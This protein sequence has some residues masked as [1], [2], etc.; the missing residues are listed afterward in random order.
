MQLK[1]QTLKKKKIHPR[2]SGWTHSNQI[3]KAENF[4]W[5][6]LE[7]RGKKGNERDHSIE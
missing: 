4:L 3:M 5:L 1:S 6:E 2:L 7:T